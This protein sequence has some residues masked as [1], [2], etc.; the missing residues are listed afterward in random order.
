MVP[1]VLGFPLIVTVLTGLLPG[2]QR[3]VFAVTDNTPEVKV[4]PTVNKIVVLP[5]P[6]AIVVPAGLVHTYGVGPPT[7]GTGTMEYWAKELQILVVGPEINPGWAGILV[8]T[9]LHRAALV[10][11]APVAVTQ[12]LAPG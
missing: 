8:P 12:R 1:G 2:V 9:A 5:C 10:P 7:P 6:L 4:E 3:L 11:H